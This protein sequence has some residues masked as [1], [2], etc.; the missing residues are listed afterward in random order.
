MVRLLGPPT[1]GDPVILLRPFKVD[2]TPTVLHVLLHNKDPVSGG[3]PLTG[4]G[5]VPDLGPLFILFDRE[6]QRILLPEWIRD[7]WR[8]TGVRC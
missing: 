4:L 6:E 3:R 8:K 2:D 1:Y 5:T 7:T